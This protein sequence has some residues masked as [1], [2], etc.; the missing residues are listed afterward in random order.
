QSWTIPLRYQLRGGA[1]EEWNN[2]IH[3][4]DSIRLDLFTEGP[5]Y[6][7]W[8]SQTDGCFTVSSLRRTLVAEIF[9]GCDFFP[10]K[11]V[12]QPAAPTK[13]SCFCWKV[14]FS[15]IA[16]VDNLQRKGFAFVNKCVLCNANLES[17]DHIFLDCDFASKVW[18]LLSSRLS[19][20]GLFHSSIASFI[21]GWKELNCVQSFSSVMKVLLH[22]VLWYIWKERNSRIFKDSSEP[23]VFTFRR[24]GTAV[25]D[26]LRVNGSFSSQDLI[27]WRRVIFD[28][29]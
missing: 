13:V 6:I 25:G 22:A 14:F 27:L 29:G 24:I 26:W 15:K 8:T 5:A 28:N 20:F 2:L 21:V 4:L 12:W 23:P 10:A 17:V 16:T 18:T 9:K 1:L 7:R 11:V 3:Y 19:I